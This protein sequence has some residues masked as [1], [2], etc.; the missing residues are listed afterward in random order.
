MAFGRTKTDFAFIAKAEGEEQF[1]C[2]VVEVCMEYVSVVCMEH[3]N[4]VCMEYV[5]VVCMEHAH[6]VWGFFH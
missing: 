1:F 6:H 4:V 3:V 2:F 5:N